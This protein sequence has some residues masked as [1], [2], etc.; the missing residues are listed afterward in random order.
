[1]W[2]FAGAGVAGAGTDAVNGP[3]F[4][5]TAGLL[6]YVSER[7]DEMPAEIM[8]QAAPGTLMEKVRYW[9]RENW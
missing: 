9:L 8:A 4:A 6:A 3:A 7:S 2:K 1:M 5:T